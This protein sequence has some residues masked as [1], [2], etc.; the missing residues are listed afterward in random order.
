M[1]ILVSGVL[2]AGVSYQVTAQ[3][4]RSC[5]AAWMAAEDKHTY[6]KTVSEGVDD[7]SS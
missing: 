7:S 4:T 1:Y 6:L 3:R 5:Q 2:A